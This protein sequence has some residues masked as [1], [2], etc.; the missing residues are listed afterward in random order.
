MKLCMLVSLIVG[1]AST[2]PPNKLMLFENFMN[3]YGKSYATEFEK[4]KR[5]QIFSENV[6]FI[7]ATN[8]QNKT[9]ELGITK[10]ADL[11]FNE[12]KS[13]HLNGFKP[14]LTVTKNKTRFSAPTGFAAPSSVDWVANGGVTS[15]KNQGHCGSC[16]SFSTVG[17]LEGAMFVAGRPLKELSMQHIIACDKGGYGCHGGLMDQAFEWVQQ[18]GVTALEDEPYLCQDQSSSACRHMKCSNKANLVLKPGD[19]VDYTDVDDSESAL[20]AAVAQ[21]PVSVAIEADKPVF[22]HYRRGVLTS[23]ACGS[24]LDHGVLAVG[25]GVENG[26]KYWKLKNSWGTIFGEEG[27]IRIAR[28]KSHGG[29]CGIRKAPSFPTVKTAGSLVV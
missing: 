2:V 5:F 4:G 19:V 11:T 7:Y 1:V 28:G 22:Q 13:D 25:Y 16:W 10:H 29:E 15:V 21:Q 23:D 3:E 12:W 18:N 9:Y 26:Q 24:N 17:A 6:D 14:L 20:E 27:Y 8:A